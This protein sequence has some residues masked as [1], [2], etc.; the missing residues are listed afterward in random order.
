MEKKD[1]KKEVETEDKKH[2]TIYHAC[3]HDMNYNPIEEFQEK[4]E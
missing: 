3:G 4:K 1:E 2:P